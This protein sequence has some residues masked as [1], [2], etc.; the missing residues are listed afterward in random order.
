VKKPAEPPLGAIVHGDIRV[1]Q[2]KSGSR[3]LARV[4]WTHA[5]THHREEATRQFGSEHAAQNWIDEQV[6]I[7]RTG[8]NPGQT[9]AD[10]VASIGTS[11]ARG[12]DTS[13]T[14]DP[15]SA[16]IRRRVLPTL[17][18]LP[19]SMVTAGVIDRAIDR[20]ES[21]YGASTVKNTVA[22]LVLVLDQ[23]M[24]DGLISRNPAKDRARRQQ[25]GRRAKSHLDETNPRDLALPDVATLNSLVRAVVE[26]GNHQCWGDVVTLLATTAMRIS[27][28]SGLLVGDVDLKAGL[29]HVERQTYPGRGGLITKATKGRRRRI[30]PIIDPLRPT[31]E[32]LTAG[33]TE[34]TR[35]VIGPR[36]GVITTATLRDATEWDKVVGQL[37]L[38]G[39]VRHGLRHTALT[40]MAD[41]GTD[42][43]VLQRVAGHQDPAVTA[44]YLHPDHAAVLA[45]G[46]RF[47]AWWGLN[48]DLTADIGDSGSSVGGA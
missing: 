25:V 30:V 16:G 10:Y 37:G 36:G 22:A 5:V 42:L 13:S 9:V 46:S 14:M 3:Y 44:R 23:A 15:Y 47:S 29:I 17:G 31:L 28:V 43:Y 4:R 8:I 34:T 20:W 6:G 7:A 26:Q 40:W 35:L 33:R 48:G 2:A 38:A 24:R 27:E 1:R 12:I 21:E 19:V 11:W 18:Q 32:R 45:A 41:A 39:L